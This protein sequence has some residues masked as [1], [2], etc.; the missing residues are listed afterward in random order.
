MLLSVL[1]LTSL[2]GGHCTHAHVS[3]VSYIGHVIILI[4]LLCLCIYNL[5]IDTISIHALSP[6]AK[7]GIEFISSNT[8]L[9]FKCDLCHPRDTLKRLFRIVS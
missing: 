5:H 6:S 7:F 1:M 8:H 9:T 3:L 4:I 2:L